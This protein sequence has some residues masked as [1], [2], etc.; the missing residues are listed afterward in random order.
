MWIN[1][2]GWYIQ[3]RGSAHSLSIF[4]FQNKPKRTVFPAAATPLAVVRCNAYGEGKLR[5]SG[6][7]SLQ[8][9]PGWKR[10]IWHGVLMSYGVGPPKRSFKQRS[11]CLT[12][13][14]PEHLIALCWNIQDFTDTALSFFTPSHKT[15]SPY[16]PLR[17]AHRQ[18]STYVSIWSHSGTVP[19]LLCFK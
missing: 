19:T 13:T 8:A 16:S 15:P 6:E 5:L 11:D 10:H 14:V 2:T 9:L 7:G 17:Q 4:L 12:V 18:K 3:S 1:V